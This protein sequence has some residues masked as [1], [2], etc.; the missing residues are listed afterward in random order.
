MATSLFQMI[1]DNQIFLPYLLVYLSLLSAASL[2]FP[3]DLQQK[4]HESTRRLVVRQAGVC[5]NECSWITQTEACNSN[6]AC[7]CQ[8]ITTAGQAGV[9]AC[10]NCLFPLNST[11]ALEAIQVGQYCGVQ[12]A[13]LVTFTIPPT[14][15]TTT[16]S[17]HTST[18]SGSITTTI[19]SATLTP[20]LP[21]LSIP[22]TKTST[23]SSNTETS[24]KSIL[25]STSSSPTGH[26]ASQ[27]PIPNESS[28]SSSSGLSGGAI[29]GIV[30]GIVGIFIILAALMFWLIRRYQKQLQPAPVSAGGA[31]PS[32]SEKPPP[33]PVREDAVPSGRL[34]YPL[35]FQDGSSDAAGGRLSRVY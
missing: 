5:T 8:I 24:S 10:A 19:T 22:L 6:V 18:S 13:G 34:R 21:G 11:I 32:F 31:T 15:S 14:S 29:G 26:D 27:T 16:T 17:T 20:V 3:T 33:A 30:G 4:W 7:D 9:A 1:T 28:S 23:S 35:D 25:S 12:A 2:A